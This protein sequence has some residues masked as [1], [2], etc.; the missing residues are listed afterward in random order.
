[1]KT[2]Q[3]KRKV[4]LQVSNILVLPDAFTRVRP[5]RAPP[6]STATITFA[7]TMTC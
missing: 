3:G 4:P 1:M 7:S 6:S 2:I 5:F